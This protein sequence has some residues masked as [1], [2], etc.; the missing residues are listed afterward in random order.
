MA[1]YATYRRTG[2]RNRIYS[3][4]R[5]SESGFSQNRLFVGVARRLGHQS[6]NIMEIGYL[7]QFMDRRTGGNT[8]NHL[9]AVNFLF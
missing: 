1:F 4:D 5:G 6:S 3:T 8:A 2:D 9:L 7:N